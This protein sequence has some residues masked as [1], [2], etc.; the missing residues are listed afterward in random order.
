MKR[1]KEFDE[2]KSKKAAELVKYLADNHISFDVLE[3]TRKYPYQ[4]CQDDFINQ[5]FRVLH[6][7]LVNSVINFC[8]AHNI[9]IDEFHL[10]ADNLRE[11]IKHGEWTSCTDSSLRLDKYTDDYFELWEEG[12]LPDEDTYNKVMAK[13]EPYLFSM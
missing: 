12:N 4:Q 3:D 6:K 8:K 2:N 10:S 7:N 1:I 5:E 11:S 13:Q 9:E